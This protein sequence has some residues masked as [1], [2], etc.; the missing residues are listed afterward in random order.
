M[1]LLREGQFDVAA[2][3]IRE[4]NTSPPTVSGQFGDVPM[5]DANSNQLP[6][7]EA[8]LEAGNNAW[9]NDFASDTA[10]SESLQ[11]Q[12]G[13]MYTILSEIRQ[14]RN[15]EPAI[16]WARENSAALEARASNLEFELVRLQYVRLQAEQDPEDSDSDQPAIDAMEY[17]RRELTKFGVRYDK[18]VHELAGSLSFFFNVEDSPFA[19]FYRGL[20]PQDQTMDGQGGQFSRLRGYGDDAYEDVATSF[21][22]EFCSLLGLS[23]QSPLY[24]AVTAGAIALPTLL[25]LQQ[26]MRS[27]GAEWT[28]KEE[29]PVRML[30]PSAFQA[31]NRPM[32]RSKP[33]FLLRIVSTVSSFAP[34]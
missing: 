32:C 22:R 17:A 18:E 33:R 1:H 23:A 15:L 25:K 8:I 10:T 13:Q 3:F 27:R 14:N 5:S 19:K 24:V 11:R 6:A 34:F 31:S 4:A 30:K 16:Q 12:F 2:T 26:V 9:A 21:T 28:T 29:L 7:E 20:H